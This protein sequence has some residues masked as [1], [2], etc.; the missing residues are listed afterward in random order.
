MIKQ[1]LFKYIEKSKLRLT[2]AG[3][4]LGL[5]I[6]MVGIHL[7]MDV[8]SLL[9]K[10]VKINEEFIVLNKHIGLLNMLS[11]EPNYFSKQELDEF[12]KVKGVAAIAPFEPSR[13]RVMMSL[14]SDDEQFKQIDFRTLLFFESI[15]KEF[16]DMEEVNWSWKQGQ[17]VP[18][19]MSSEYMKLYNLTFAGTQD[20]PI[21][22][23]GILKSFKFQLRI[24]GRN[25]QS[26]VATGQ[27]VGFS[28]RINSILVP[29]EFIEWGNR[30]FATTESKGATRVVVKTDDISSSDFRDFIADH[31]YDINEDKFK[32]G[33]TNAILKT[34]FAITSIV[35]LFVILLAFLGF[36]QY[37]Q[38]LTYKSAYEIKTLNLQG[39]SLTKLFVPYKQFTLRNLLI[40]FSGALLVF[41][42]E[43]IIILKVIEIP[44][45]ELNLINTSSGLILGL[46]AVSIMGFYILRQSKNQ[47]KRIIEN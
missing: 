6:L 30:N 15:P 38:L 18:I 14:D 12:S 29:Q 39:Y 32:A 27:L 46:A 26:T 22:S 3:G 7:F 2:I 41:V 5:A 36:V 42:I 9:I 24:E 47:L 44:G 28:D 34:A 37:N 45:Y 8:K 19:L 40:M 11:R 20:L 13:F 4:I 43:H 16:I 33:K 23:E 25:G 10:K 35:A 21:V 1:L 17:V 31:N